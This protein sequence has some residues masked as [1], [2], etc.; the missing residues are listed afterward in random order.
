M[1]GG[2]K[3][4]PYQTPKMLKKVSLSSENR[5]KGAVNLTAD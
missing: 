3:G 4:P 5:Q 1:R 2:I